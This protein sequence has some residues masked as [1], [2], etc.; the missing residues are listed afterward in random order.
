MCLLLLPT[1]PLALFFRFIPLY[2]MKIILPGG[3]GQIGTALANRLHSDGHQVI[4]LSR[5][6][7]AVPWQVT[8]WDTHSLG[9]WATELNEADVVINLA[10]RSVNCRY[11][12]AN[13]EEIKHSRI[14]TTELIG[15]AIKLCQSPP[16]L[17]LNS[18][19]ATIYN[20]RYDAPNDE[21]SGILG[22]QD[23]QSPDTWRFSIDVAES[24]EHA[25]DKFDLPD[26][27]LTKLR[28][29]MVMGPGRGGVF[30]VFTR[31]ARKGLGGTLGDGRQ[32]VSW[33]H[34]ED[35]IRAILWIIENKNLVGPVNLCAPNPLPNR[36]FMKALRQAC[37]APFGLPASKWMLEIGTFF[38]RTETELVL[39]SRRVVPSR[40]IESGFIF[41]HPTWP[42]AV[43]DLHRLWKVAAW[44]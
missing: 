33:I 28:T 38:M 17:W 25:A 15:Q 27:R 8:Q 20:H 7:S 30:D 19:T 42:Q 11:T 44:R 9:S 35:F 14:R 5:S 37:G 1:D 24:W 2:I 40:L 39:K 21:A 26:T 32:F 10:G 13:R 29:S 23:T 34:E 3:S 4:V 6:P 22:S 41:K 18:S 31:L 12:V 43:E 36:D 16:S